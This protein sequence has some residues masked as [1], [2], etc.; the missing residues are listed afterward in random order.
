MLKN[1]QE[2]II[3][4]VGKEAAEDNGK[5]LQSKIDLLNSQI[6]HYKHEKNAVEES[7]DI[8]IK[9]LR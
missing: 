5:S 8:E 7:A 6:E 3:T 1:Q 9:H 2:L 4:K